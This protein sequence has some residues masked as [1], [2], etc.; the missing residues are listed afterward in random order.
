MFFKPFRRLYWPS[1][2]HAYRLCGDKPITFD[3]GL[4]SFFAILLGTRILLGIGEGLYYPM[5]NTIIKIGS[6]LENEVE[7]IRHGS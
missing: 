5:Q 3:W 1:K 2:G 6:L 7:R 4:S